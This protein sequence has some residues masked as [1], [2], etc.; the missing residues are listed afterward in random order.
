M[1]WFKSWKQGET[2]EVWSPHKPT[3]LPCVLKQCYDH[4]KLTLVRIP[5]QKAVTVQ[6][7]P[8]TAINLRLLRCAPWQRDCRMYIC[9]LELSKLF[10]YSC[11]KWYCRIC[12]GKLAIRKYKCSVN[13]Y[14]KRTRQLWAMKWASAERSGQRSRYSWMWRRIAGS[15]STTGSCYACWCGGWTSWVWCSWPRNRFRRTQQ[16]LTYWSAEI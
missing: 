15:P 2:Q 13:S 14:F 8:I 10:L 5:E 6:S 4:E 3:L 9:S 12:W 11:Y 7:S 16:R 1:N